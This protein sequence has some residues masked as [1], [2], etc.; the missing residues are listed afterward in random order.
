MIPI[1]II[2]LNITHPLTITVTQMTHNVQLSCTNLP[3]FRYF[4]IVLKI[5]QNQNYK[6]IRKTLQFYI[7]DDL[8]WYINST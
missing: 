1:H 2:E 4:H 5:H 6:F 8:F 7:L 3:Y